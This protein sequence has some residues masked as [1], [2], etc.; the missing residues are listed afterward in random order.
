MTALIVTALLAS[1][2]AVVVAPSFHHAVTA[3][4]LLVQDTSKRL[5]FGLGTLYGLALF[6]PLLTWI[7]TIG[8]DAWLLLAITQALEL[9]LLAL[10]LVMATA[11]A[12]TIDWA[13]GLLSTITGWP[14]FSCSLAATM[15]AIR[16]LPPPGE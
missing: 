11:S 16:S 8:D 15:R 2:A 4:T 12:A 3:I 5:A 13:P 1:G 6:I 10:G 7:R 9:G 14:S